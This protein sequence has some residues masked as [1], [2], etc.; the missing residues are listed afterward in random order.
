MSVT[1]DL[2]ANDSLRVYIQGRETVA[3]AWDARTFTPGS[4][5]ELRIL[6]HTWGQKTKRTLCLMYVRSVAVIYARKSLR[7]LEVRSN[8]LHVLQMY[9]VWC[10]PKKMSSRQGKSAYSKY[11]YNKHRLII[12]RNTWVSC[13]STNKLRYEDLDPRGYSALLLIDSAVCNVHDWISSI[14]TSLH[15][16]R[17]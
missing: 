2:P 3:T 16:R 13:N 8:V 11:I 9:C 14:G 4:Q 15:W 17:D 7:V 12:Y 6:G 1:S 10:L 5:S